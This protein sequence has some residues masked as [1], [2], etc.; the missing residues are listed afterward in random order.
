VKIVIKGDRNVGKT[1]L[2]QRLQGNPFQEE[3]QATDEIQVTAIQ[4]NYKATDDVVKVEVWDVVDKSKKRKKIDGLKIHDQSEDGQDDDAMEA[5]LDAEF[6]DVYKGSNGVIMVF[7]LTKAWTFEYIQRELPK[8]PTHIP[9]LILANHR[10][11][12]HHRVVTEDQVRGF[13]EELGRHEGAGS[14]QVRYAEAS[15]RNGFGLKFLHKFFNLPFLHLQRETYLKLLETNCRDIQTTCQELDILEDS[16][17]QDYDK[18]LDFIT[19]RRRQVADQHGVNGDGPARSV[20]V[21]SNMKCLTSGPNQNQPII[22]KPSPSIIIGAHNPLPNGPPA[23]NSPVAKVEPQRKELTSQ[24]LSNNIVATAAKES[25]EFIPEDDQAFRSF[26]E[27]PPTHVENLPEV[28]YESDSDDDA[29]SGNPMVSG[30]L[31]DLEGEEE[32]ISVS[33]TAPDTTIMTPPESSAVSATESF[34]S[35]SIKSSEDFTKISSVDL[36]VT[37]SGVKSMSDQASEA[38]SSKSKSSKKNSKKDGKKS[39]KEKKEGKGHKKKH[40][41]SREEEEK[42]RLEEFLGPSDA[43]GDDAQDYELF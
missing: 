20:S 21:P 34:R 11:M 22:N 25:L 23:K 17:E 37:S 3:Y 38:S 30:F 6:I 13:I 27:E 19:N 14:G 43:A 31:E 10:D 1:C 26:L 24:V 18:F 16:D 36:K 28:K 33:N 32:E 9:V 4:W 15:M 8:V 7:D 40:K 5:A 39:S 35:L 42:K 2:F 12:G 29:T 41:L